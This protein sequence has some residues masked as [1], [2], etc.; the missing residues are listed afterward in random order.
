MAPKRK[1]PDDDVLLEILQ[2]LL[3]VTLYQGGASKDLIAR[4]IGRRKDWVVSLLKGLP[5]RRRQ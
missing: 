1:A 4:M 2:K 3:A 5:N